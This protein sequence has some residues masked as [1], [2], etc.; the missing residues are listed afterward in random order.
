MLDYIWEKHGCGVPNV[1]GSYILLMD[2]KTLPEDALIEQMANASQSDFIFSLD[3]FQNP[4][5]IFC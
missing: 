4:L 1:V 2:I 3:I 5:I